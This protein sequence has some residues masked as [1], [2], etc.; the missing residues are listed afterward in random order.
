[1]HE[2]YRSGAAFFRRINI[3]LYLD[4]FEGITQHSLLKLAVG[5]GEAIVLTLVLGPG[6]NQKALQVNI[7][8]FCISED[9]P[10]RRSVTATNSL[11]FMDLM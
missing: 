6:I 9:T 5:Q 11:I 3:V 4:R 2:A 1:M 8:S 7:R 10:A